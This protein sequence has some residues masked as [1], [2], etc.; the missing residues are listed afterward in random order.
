MFWFIFL[1][2]W[3]VILPSF[4]LIFTSKIDALRYQ[5]DGASANLLG[6]SCTFG[7]AWIGFM[8]FGVILSPVGFIILAINLFNEL[9]SSAED[10]EQKAYD[11]RTA[12]REKD[13]AM[14]TMQA[15]QKEILRQ[16]SELREE[17]RTP[18]RTC[19]KKNTRKPRKRTAKT[20]T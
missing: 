13:Q 2:V 18:K 19:R 16:L 15:E 3:L 5:A 8:F 14:A 20:S 9:L 6:T 1:T 4:S 7:E 17:L 12:D 10:L 11:Q